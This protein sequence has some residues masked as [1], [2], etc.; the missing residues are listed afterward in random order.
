M[1]KPHDHCCDHDNSCEHEHCNET[2]FGEANE[3]PA[4]FSYKKSIQLNKGITGYELS[5]NLVDSFEA[6]KL[7]ATQNKYFIGH[8]KLFIENGESNFD[9][10]ISTTGNKVNVKGS[11]EWEKSILKNCNLNMTAIIFGVEEYILRKI[12]IEKFNFN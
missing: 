10:W 2:L 7:W 11:I 6:I 1:D 4:V 9:L 8:I 5:V 3:V 12:I